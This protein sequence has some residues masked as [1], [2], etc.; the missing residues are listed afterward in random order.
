MKRLSRADGWLKKKVEATSDDSV[1]V[2]QLFLTVLNR[3]PTN[4]ERQSVEQHFA[5]EKSREFAAQ[6]VVWALLRSK[7][8][9]RQ[10]LE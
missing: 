4:E 8:F 5:T 3:H 1:L 6:D 7:E 10:S 2:S 9:L